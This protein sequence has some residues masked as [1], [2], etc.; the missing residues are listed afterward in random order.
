MQLTRTASNPDPAT[1]LTITY[2]PLKEARGLKIQTSTA[3]VLQVL[4][5]TD[6][7]NNNFKTSEV[8]SKEKQDKRVFAFLKHNLYT[9]NDPTKRPA[10]YYV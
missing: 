4:E 8:I 5:G 3:R 9:I 10:Q 7:N 2:Y 6:S 1:N